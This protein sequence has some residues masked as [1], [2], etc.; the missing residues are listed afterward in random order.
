MATALG[1][2]KKSALREAKTYDFTWEATAPGGSEKKKGEMT[3]VSANAVRFNLRRMGLMPTVVRKA[4][5]P[6]FGEKGVKEAQLVVMVRQL[7]TMINAGV[8]IVQSFELLV[9]A[10]SGA[11][12]KKL[13][14][15]ILKHLKEGESLSQAMAHFPKY[16]DR[17]F[18]SL[19]AAGEQGGILDTI[20]LRLAEYRE[21][22]LALNKKVKSA[23]FYPAAIIT[24]MVVVV[25]ILMI[26]VIPVF[27]QLFSSFGA[28]LPLLTQVVINISDWMKSHWYIVVLVPIASVWLFIYAYKRNLSFKTVI[29]RFSLKIPVLGD[30]LLKGAV[31]RFMRTLSTMQGAGVPI[32][33]ALGTLSKVSGNVIIERSVLAARDDVATGGRITTQLKADGVFPIMATQM[34]AIGEETGAVEVM[35]G[36]VAD[37]YEN[38]VEEAVSRLSTLMEPMIMV[39]LGIIVGTLV[40]AMY[41]P[42]FK[43]GAVVTH[44]G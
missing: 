39:V 8:P 6:L 19:V 14:K 5:Q 4:P 13:L 34:L 1:K 15:G 11:G 38:E 17:L 26:F 23:M 42:I 44:G 37:F 40:I 43:M 31:A 12:M 10:T 25:V 36:K 16:F 20:L 32:M 41:L 33:E 9:S 24:V 27:S 29:D 35:S 28:T 30:I 2:D 3:A 7:S 18:V 22:T 21:K